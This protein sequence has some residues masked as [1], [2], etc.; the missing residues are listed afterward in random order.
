MAWVAL[1]LVYVLLHFLCYALVLRHQ[2]RFTRERVIFAY[3]ASSELGWALVLPIGGIL[4]VWTNEGL[5]AWIAAVALHGIY[6]LTFLTLWSLASGGYSIGILAQIDAVGHGQ[7]VERA[8]LE[9]IGSDK[10]DARLRGVQALGLIRSR[11]GYLEH[12]HRGAWAASV[13]ASIAGVFAVRES[14]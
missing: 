1:T 11:D 10:K 2:P 4:G 13:L 14:G 3:H 9:L 8:D 6:S 12:T 7:A 5:A